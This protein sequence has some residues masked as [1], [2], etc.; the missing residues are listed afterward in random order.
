MLVRFFSRGRGGSA[1]PINY[2][3]GKK[4]D[5]LGASVLR[6]DVQQTAD[7][8]DAL[9]FRRRY[10]SGCLSFAEKTITADTKNSIMDEFERAIFVGLDRD[11]YDILWIEHTDKDRI[12]LN[13]VIPNVELLSG[14]RL[15]PYFDK[16]D[17]NRIN[18]YQQYI[19][20]KFDLADPN[21]PARKR[22]LTTVADLP[23]DKEL[24]AHAITGGLLSLVKQGVIINRKGVIDALAANGFTITRETKSSISIAIDGSEKP[25]RL[26]G[27]IYEREFEFD[28][29]S[30]SIR[31]QCE[32]AERDYR[33]ALNARCDA[34]LAAFENALAAKQNAFA[35]RYSRDR[36]ATII[37]GETAVVDQSISV[38]ISNA[39][40]G[41]AIARSNQKQTHNHA[42]R[43]ITVS[44]SVFFGAGFRR[45]NDTIDRAGDNI[46][47]RSI[48]INERL[49]TAISSCITAA[50][51]T[52]RAAVARCVAASVDVGQRSDQTRNAQSAADAAKNRRAWERIAGSNQPEK[53]RQQSIIIDY[54]SA[55][56]SRENEN[57]GNPSMPKM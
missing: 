57:P 12:E 27:A 33:T 8:I 35:K 26:K 31:A 3:L 52:A 1:G 45:G 15:Q 56:L 41:P 6:G 49:R 34:S 30:T 21:D 51:S 48:S 25:L 44:Q 18:H 29:S 7:L 2:L 54:S 10:T 5:R 22:A 23:K 24:A 14:K 32:A 4:R 19:N 13:F 16:A 17:R 36:S 42:A 11:Q 9:K 38:N 53:S 46:I 50:I 43:A 20:A 55:A 40:T 28:A 47:N 37:P 39:A